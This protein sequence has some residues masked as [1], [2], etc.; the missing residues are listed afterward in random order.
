MFVERRM[1]GFEGDG[2]G[3]QGLENAIPSSLNSLGMLYVCS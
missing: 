2:G 3:G 1:N